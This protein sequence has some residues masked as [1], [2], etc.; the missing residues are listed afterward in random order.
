MLELIH[1][2]VTQ[3][4]LGLAVDLQTKDTVAKDNRQSLRVGRYV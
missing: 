2:H 3:S 4:N 1:R